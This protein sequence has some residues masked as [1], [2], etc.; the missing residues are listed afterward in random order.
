MAVFPNI[1]PDKVKITQSYMIEVEDIQT[2][3]DLQELILLMFNNSESK[4]HYYKE[5]DCP[6]NGLLSEA[7]NR[8]DILM[9][10]TEFFYY[11]HPKHKR[12][13]VKIAR[14]GGK[15]EWQKEIAEKGPMFVRI[16]LGL[17]NKMKRQL[18]THERI[19]IKRQLD[20][21]PLELKPNFYGIGID[22]VK[23]FHRLKNWLSRF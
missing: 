18:E 9:N 4:F 13:Y 8:G 10:T 5:K 11:K 20:T 14:D 16:T 1:T 12:D 22:L 17:S 19:E 6:G 3:N 23:V 7:S 21:N 2:E 15:F